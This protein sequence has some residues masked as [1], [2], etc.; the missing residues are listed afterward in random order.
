MMSKVLEAVGFVNY[1]TQYWYWSY[2]GLYWAFYKKKPY[3][4]FGS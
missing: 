2:G 4:R 3:A 1:E